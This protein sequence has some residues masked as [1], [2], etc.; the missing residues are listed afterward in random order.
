LLQRERAARVV[1]FHARNAAN[2]SLDEVM[3][4]LVAGTWGTK[5]PAASGAAA[6]RRVAQRAV[7]D[8]LIAL[9]ADP[10][11]TAEVRAA[12][13]WQLREI[14][15]RLL[16]KSNGD[17]AEEAHRALAAG[18]IQRFLERRDA[19]TT[20]PPAPATPPGTPIGGR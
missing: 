13:E 16:G 18:D 8:R 11:A 5:A 12:A 7:L 1:A 19:P 9:A 15:S 4:R 3:T 20:P 2:P 17:T 14:A 10:R 6:L